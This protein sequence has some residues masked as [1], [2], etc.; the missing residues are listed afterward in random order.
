MSGSGVELPAL[1]VEGGGALGSYQAGAYELLLAAS[2]Q[3]GWA[4]GI[5]IGAINGAIICGNPPERRVEQLAKFWRQTSSVITTA[6]P[7][8]EDGVLRLFDDR[9]RPRPRQHCDPRA[10]HD[11]DLRRIE[12]RP[13]QRERVETGQD[14]PSS[15]LGPRQ[16]KPQALQTFLG[17]NRNPHQSCGRQAPFFGMPPVCGAWGRRANALS[18]KSVGGGS[19]NERNR[20]A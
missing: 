15:G 9:R 11:R 18:V 3:I 14:R 12:G 7:N 5:S 16:A 4:A 10:P 8:G 13:T 1:M 20:S 2:Q 19:Q 17:Q 6:P